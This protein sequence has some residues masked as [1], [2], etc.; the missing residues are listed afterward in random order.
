M[1][2]K[3]PNRPENSNKGT[4]GKVLNIAGSWNY[5]GAAY[6]SSVSALKVGAGLVTLSADRDVIASVSAL[7]PDVVYISRTETLEN[8]EKFSVISIGCGLGVDNSSRVFFQQVLEK[9]KDLAT[10]VII[11]AS[12]LQLLAECENVKLPSELILTPHPGEASRL[13]NIPIDEIVD[14][15]E[16]YAKLLAKK[17]NAVAL[18]KGKNTK[19]ATYD[20]RFYVN[21]TGNSAL[22]KAGS[23]DVL[24]GMISGFIA[25]GVQPFEATCL[26]TYLHGLAGELAGGELTQYGVLASDLLKYIPLAMKTLID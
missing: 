8:L 5:Q 10:P 14:N 16:Q 24:T 2:F 4:F 3:L 19:I 23:G 9:L 15:S 7:T 20:E 1:E 12:G 21:N 25:Q 17:Y 11:D 13:L 26:A 18:I 6:L 22:A